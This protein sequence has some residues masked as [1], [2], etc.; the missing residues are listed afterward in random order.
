MGSDIEPPISPYRLVA[1]LRAEIPFAASPLG[2]IEGDCNLKHLP[3]YMIAYFQRAS[4]RFSV[5]RT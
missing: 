4:N 5:C 3:R 1:A 2:S